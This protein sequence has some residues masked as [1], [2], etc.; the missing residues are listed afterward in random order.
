MDK[1][2]IVIGYRLSE[3][4]TILKEF[5]EPLVVETITPFEDKKEERKLS[6]PIVV[7]QVNEIDDIILTVSFFR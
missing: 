4:R 7:R 1:I 5:N 3:A 6:E 2:P